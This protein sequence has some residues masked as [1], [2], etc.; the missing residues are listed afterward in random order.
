[1][2]ILQ[3][4]SGRQI[5]GAIMHCL[6]LSEQLAHRGHDVTVMCLR[7]SWMW[8]QLPDSSVK[9]VACNMKR[10]PSD[11]SFARTLIRKGQFDLMHSHLSRAHFFGVIQRQLTGVPCVATAQS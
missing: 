1:M 2:K 5:N 9:R 10:W 7:N 4:V 3:L 11:L 6:L 8:R